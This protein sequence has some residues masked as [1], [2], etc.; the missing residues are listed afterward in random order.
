MYYQVIIR[1]LLRECVACLFITILLF[2]LVTACTKE[3][4]SMKGGS[5][6]EIQIAELKKWFGEI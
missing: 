5:I 2:T 1:M 4:A 3:P 6:Q